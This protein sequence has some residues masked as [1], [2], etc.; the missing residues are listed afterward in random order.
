MD[1]NQARA[2]TQA[3]VGVLLRTL[4]DEALQLLEEDCFF[5]KQPLLHLVLGDRADLLLELLAK[6][7]LQLEE[8]DALAELAERLDADHAVLMLAAQLM[9]VLDQPLLELPLHDLLR[10]DIYLRSVALGHDLLVSL[11]LPLMQSLSAVMR[12]LVEHEKTV[13]SQS[14]VRLMARRALS[15][16]VFVDGRLFL[17]LVARARDNFRD[18]LLQLTHRAHRHLELVTGASL[19]EDLALDLSLSPLELLLFPVQQVHCV[20]ALD[21]VL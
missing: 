19:P 14:R 15:I 21:L 18:L 3:R 4:L 10:V 11:L 6:L 16:F 13:V 20:E 2:R 12:V 9:Q 7:L 1:R 17:L 5:F 8:P